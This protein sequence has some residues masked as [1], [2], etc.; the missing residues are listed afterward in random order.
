MSLKPGK[1]IFDN[2]M[3][4]LISKYDQFDALNKSVTYIKNVVG[5]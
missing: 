3:E 5:C 1:I 4:E 2:E